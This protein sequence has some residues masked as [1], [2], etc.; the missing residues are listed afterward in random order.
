[1]IDR[2]QT[3]EQLIKNSLI[4]LKDGS[5]KGD[6]LS[7]L[8]IENRKLNKNIQFSQQELNDMLI[9]AFDYIPPAEEPPIINTLDMVIEKP[10]EWLITNYIPKNEVTILCG[11]GGTGKGFVS[12]AI[13]SAISSGEQVFFESEEE[14]LK[15]NRQP[16]KVLFISS[17]E[18]ISKVTKRKMKLQGKVI[19]KNI[20]VL[21]AENEYTYKVKI[22]SKELEKLIHSIKPQL[23]IID[24]IQAFLPPNTNMSDKTTMRD[25]M[26]GLK[27]L[28]VKEDTTFLILSHT[29]KRES[30]GR[31]RVGDSAEIWDASRCVFILGKVDD[32]TRYLSQEKNNLSK[33]Q[34][35]TLFEIFDG[36]V[37][38]KGITDKKDKDFVGANF[39]KTKGNP[40][41]EIQKLF[42]QLLRESETKSIEN[43]ALKQA[44]VENSG[45]SSSTFERAKKELVEDGKIEIKITGKGENRTSTVLLKK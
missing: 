44:I 28:A 30:Y 10:T 43:R 3:K 7:A 38:F 35:T 26:G 4:A 40:R 22:G 11:D 34:P 31:Q 24:P 5:Y 13:T 27:A 32:N 6:L 25:Y 37:I 29:N 14:Y 18:D 17:E 36:Q 15:Q 9:D 42:L 12:S 1:M 23:V 20:Y 16:Q 2:N 21:G 41:E 33:T 19:E 45:Y 8:E 39:S